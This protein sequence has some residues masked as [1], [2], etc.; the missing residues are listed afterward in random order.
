MSSKYT[1]V[2]S[3]AYI[4]VNVLWR[5][6]CPLSYKGNK[7]FQTLSDP[8]IPKY[9]VENWPRHSTLLMIDHWIRI[10]LYSGRRDFLSYFFK[11]SLI[12]VA[13]MKPESDQPL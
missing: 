8:P 11:C 3:K 13:L 2:P 9:L 12:K 10:L 5:A 6:F 1:K 4:N 7:M